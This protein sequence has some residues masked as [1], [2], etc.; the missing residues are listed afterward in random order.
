MFFYASKII[1]PLFWPSSIITLLIV[2][3]AALLVTRWG[4][5]WGRR[6]LAGGVMLM[7]VCGFSPLGHW[8]VL[9]LEQRF[10]RAEIPRDIEGII[11]LGGF[12]DVYISRGRN[13]LTMNDAAERLTESVLLA[14]RRPRAKVIFT[15]GDAALI[16]PAEN[17][18]ADAVRAYLEAAGIVG[19]RLVMEGASRT[20]YE[21]AAQLVRLLSPAPEKRYVLVTSAFHMPRSMGTFRA[22]GFDVL[23]WPVDYRTSGWA[24]LA[25]P[26]PT[27]PAGLRTVDMAFKEWVGLAAYWLSG[28]S[29]DLWPGPRENLEPQRA[30]A[31]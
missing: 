30:H 26:F 16:E 2:C 1:A 25:T 7:L 8:L 19:E 20:T 4:V 12:E 29:S 18:A 22:M 31:T 6:M 24:D 9:P 14:N 23:A 3:G 11:I 13:I 15:G 27:I 17:G 21:N 5:G 10:A 28:R